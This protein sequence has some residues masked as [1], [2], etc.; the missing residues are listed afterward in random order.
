MS[1]E[2]CVLEIQRFDDRREVICIS[3]HI[4]SCGR[5]TGSPMP[6]PVNCNTAISVLG[7]KQHLT[8][9]GIGVQRPTVRER[10]GWALAPVFVV[11]CCTVF[12]RNG[13]HAFPLKCWL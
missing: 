3:V 10:Y 12:G 7:E 2:G 6:A 9:P 1:N 13:A 4:I 11:D 5:L 8:V